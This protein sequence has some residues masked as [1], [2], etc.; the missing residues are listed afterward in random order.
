MNDPHQEHLPR[1]ERRNYQRHAVVHWTMTVQKRATGWMDDAFHQHFRE[2]M[3]HASAREDLSCPAY[4]LMPDHLHLMWMGLRLGTDQLNGIKF[5]REYLNK[6]L[7]TRSSRRQSVVTSSTDSRPQLPSEFRLQKQ[8]HDHV[9]KEDE[10]RRN[11]FARVC[12]YV[13]ENPVR[14]NLVERAQDWPFSG[15]LVPGYP[16][17][18]PFEEEFWPTFWK[19]YVTKR[20]SEAPS[21]P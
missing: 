9:L 3:L 12:F 18:Q 16:S 2:L 19:V 21:Q 20:D 8:T 17:L 14:A 11:A 5:L 7:A 15:A 13:L 4:C 10:R 6:L 1:L